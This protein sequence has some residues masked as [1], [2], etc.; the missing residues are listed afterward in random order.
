M[1]AGIPTGTTMLRT[2]TSDREDRM[3]LLIAPRSRQA[4]AIARVGSLV[5]LALALAGCVSI[6]ARVWRNGQP[7]ENSGAY[8]RVLSG[9]MS[10][11]TRRE[12]QN[13]INFGALGFYREAPAFSPFPKGGAWR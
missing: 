13:A 4:N 10:F 1:L 8:Q 11:A 7:M 2:H 9:D 5:G 12:L 6:P 3:I